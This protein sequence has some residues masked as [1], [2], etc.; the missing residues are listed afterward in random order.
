MDRFAIR[1]QNGYRMAA[2]SRFAVAMHIMAALAYRD[3]ESLSSEAL[4]KSVDTNPVVIRRLLRLLAKAGLVV[5]QA[6][7]GGGSHLAKRPAQITLLDIYRA[8]DD[9]E[10][11]FALTGK[12]VNQTCAVSCCIQDL[13]GK[14]F[15][16]AE[17]ALTNVLKK[18]RLS[19]LVAQIP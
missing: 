9:A 19:D 4:A 13:A 1:N 12:P 5:A 3:G 17:T 14:V 18:K 16:E 2:N 11:L 15:A 10:P 7:K 6:G 8:I